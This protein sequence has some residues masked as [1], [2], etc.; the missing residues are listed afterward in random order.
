MIFKIAFVGIAVCLISTLLKKYLN[1]FVLPVEILYI[2]FA[3]I[4][5]IDVFKEILGVVYE[6]FT[7][8][9]NGEEI[10]S[11]VIKAMGICLITK[12]SSDVCNENGNKLVASVIEFSGRILLAVIALPYIESVINVAVAY[13][14]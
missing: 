2:S 7:T 3:T 8:L 6:H 13:L 11:S 9:E 10:I 5:L 1:E 14:E 12:F 4:M